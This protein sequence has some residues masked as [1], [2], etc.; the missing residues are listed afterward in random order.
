MS[1]I[2][3]ANCHTPIPEPHLNESG[4]K[5]PCSSCGSTLRNYGQELAAEV[6]MHATLAFKA[7]SPGRRPFALGFVGASFHRLT[8]AWHQVERV[9]FRDK[10]LYRE[11]VTDESGRVIRDVQHPLTDHKGHGDDRGPRTPDT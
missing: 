5:K 6:M 8:G 2:S 9:V 11:K 10:N 3:C 4:E 1:S 7:R